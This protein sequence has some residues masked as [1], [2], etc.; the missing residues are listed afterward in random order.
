MKFIGKLTATALVV[1]S[2]LLLAST[3]HAQADLVPGDSVSP[4]PNIVFFGGT[5][6]DT[7]V[8][9]FSA[10]N[11]TQVIEGTVLS[12]VYSG[13]TGNAGGLDFYYQIVMNDSNPLVT[14]NNSAA[15]ASFSSFLLF[16]TSVGEDLVTDIDGAGPFAASAAPEASSATRNF[17]GTGITFDFGVTGIPIGGRSTTLLVRTNATVFT[18]GTAAVLG[19]SGVS[20]NASALAPANPSVSLAPEPASL[21][22]IGMTLLGGVAVR[23]RKK[24]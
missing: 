23:R 2:T 19:S 22:L 7:L 5:L 4:V 18:T 13:G 3:A 10:V 11:G 6:E 20:A 21:A 17:A 16:T 24:A 1:G 14:G 8:S 12:A 15:S 9:T